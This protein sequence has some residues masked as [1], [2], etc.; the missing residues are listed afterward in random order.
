MMPRTEDDKR[1]APARRIAAETASTGR[2]IV[3][4]RAAA[5]RLRQ[6]IVFWAVLSGRH[7]SIGLRALQLFGTE[8]QK[9]TW[10]KPLASGEKLAAF[11]L[12][13]PEAG[14]DAANVRT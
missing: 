2:G 14:S 3:V 7:H 8:E 13:E 9:R 12:T 10:M 5:C 11:A 1:G 4:F 6:G